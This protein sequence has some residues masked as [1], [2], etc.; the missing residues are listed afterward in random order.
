MRTLLLIL[1]LGFCGCST[2][3]N[4]YKYYYEGMHFRHKENF[5]RAKKIKQIDFK[6]PFKNFISVPGKENVFISRYELSKGEYDVFLDDIKGVDAEMYY[7]SQIDYDAWKDIDHYSFLSSS[8]NYDNQFYD[9]TPIV[10]ITYQSAINYCQ[11]ATDQVRKNYSKKILVARLPSL[12]E[13]DSVVSYYDIHVEKD[14]LK[15]HHDYHG[16]LN[17]NLKYYMY[18]IK[19]DTIYPDRILDGGSIQANVVNYPQTDDGVC[20]IFGNVSE[21]VEENIVYGGSWDTLTDEM[22][23]DLTYTSPDPRIGFRLVLEILN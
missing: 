18:N 9:L 4:G 15:S 10:N 6:K 14:T 11:W 1:I 13:Y 8:A 2:P 16:E 22:F 7:K 20:S 12:E 17:A 5:K 21:M 3:G 23:K 19:F